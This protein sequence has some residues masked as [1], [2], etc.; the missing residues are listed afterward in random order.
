[1]K[2]ILSLL[3]YGSQGTLSRARCGRSWWLQSVKRPSY[4]NVQWVLLSRSISGQLTSS[5]G[6]S[7]LYR[8]RGKAYVISW[9]LI[10][11]FLEPRL[12]AYTR[13]LA[14]S[15]SLSLSHALWTRSLYASSLDRELNSLN[16]AVLCCMA[17]REIW[18]AVVYRYGHCTGRQITHGARTCEM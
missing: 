1:M 12:F 3:F 6:N 9:G 7:R 18:S 4:I 17:S 16:D 10:A 15:L 11:S 13:S 14:L 2:T 8:Y 5:I